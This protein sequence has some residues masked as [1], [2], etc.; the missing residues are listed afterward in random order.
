LSSEKN[1]FVFNETHV[2][3]ETVTDLV[4]HQHHVACVY[5]L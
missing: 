4:M 5:S 1:H 3:Y 2:L